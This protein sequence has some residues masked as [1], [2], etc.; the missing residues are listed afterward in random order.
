MSL[1]E[2]T[3]L[4]TEIASRD[5]MVRPVDGVTFSVAAG[6]IV[7]LVGES[8]SGKTMTGMSIMRLLPPG[9]SIT[10]GSIRFGGV[11]LTELDAAGMRRLRGS[12]IALISQDPM[13]AL[14]PTRTIGSQLRE[15]YRIHASASQRA[16]SARAREVLHLVGMPRPSERLNDFPHQ[17]SG[18][19]RQRAMIA[20]GLMCEPRLLIADEPTT[21]LD[22]SIQAQILELIDDLRSRLSMAVLLITHDLGVIAGHA[23]RVVVMYGGRVVEQAETAALF[24]DPRHRYTEALFESMPTMDLD[25]RDELA[26]IP[27]AP[28]RLIGLPAMCRFAPRCR[29]AREDCR[30]QDPVLTQ[31]VPGHAHACLHP[32]HPRPADAARHAVTAQRD[33]GTAQG[34]GAGPLLKLTDVSKQFEV[35][36]RRPFQHGKAVQAVSGVSLTVAAGETVGIV[37][38]SGCGKTTLGRML[39]GLERPASG[40]IT[41]DGYELGTLR[42]GQLRR[43]RRDLQM[44]FQD[45]AAALDPRMPVSALIGEP[46]AAQHVGGRRERRAAVAELLDAVGLTADAAGRYAHEFS[47]GQRQRIAMAR[48]LALKPRVIVADEPVSALDVSVQAQILNLMRSLQDRYGLTY[49]VISHDLALLKYLADRIGVMYLGRLVELGTS[50]EVYGAP[51]HPYTAGLIQS[52]PLPDP[53]RERAKTTAGLG[54]ELPSAID[55]PSGC[56]FRTRCPLATGRCAQETP[57]LSASAGLHAVACHYPLTSSSLAQTG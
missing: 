54:G 40:S 42:G 12:D 36:S 8:G 18:G 55:P 29:F 34:A 53:A 33:R 27:G 28:P 26:T 19:M 6:Q 23:D 49:V 3:G 48:A 56:R 51:R 37:G 10:A 1:L 2:V 47:G 38:E 45:S 15:T 52:I 17:L 57:R 50:E 4:R 43:H 9:G 30:A 7:G 20:M 46:L 13:S 25:A 21:A 32:A 39:V 11:E 44:M 24:A 14:N 16:A 5:G 35:R 41:F 31:I 22:V